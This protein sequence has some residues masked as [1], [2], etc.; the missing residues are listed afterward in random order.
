MFDG[1][2]RVRGPRLHADIL[3]HLEP[4]M[5][6]VGPGDLC[7]PAGGLHLYEDRLIGVNPHEQLAPSV[8]GAGRL[9]AE[10]AHPAL[11]GEEVCYGDLV[12]GDRTLVLPTLQ[13]G[14]VVMQTAVRRHEIQPRLPQLTADGRDAMELVGAQPIRPLGDGVQ[15]GIPEAVNGH[16]AIL[17][18][19]TPLC[20]P[21][22][23][24]ERRDRYRSVDY[25]SGLRDLQLAA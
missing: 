14:S 11:G 7:L 6:S 8:H 15:P 18:L 13:S 21:D 25:E 12:E 9:P 3:R 10:D 2:P 4:W 23:E 5:A 19:P 16:G 20:L 22:L 1:Y 17:E 24:Q